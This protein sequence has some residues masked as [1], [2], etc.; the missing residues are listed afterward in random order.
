M[1]D[2]DR[3]LFAPILVMGVSACGKSEIA[4]RLAATIE[5]PFVEGDALHPPSNTDKMSRGVPLEDEDRWPWLNALADEVEALAAEKGGAVFS[6]SALK[7]SYRSRLRARLP[8]LI[9]VYLKLD[10]ETAQN[11]AAGRNGHFMPAALVE[12]QFATLECPRGEQNT[13][14]VDAR[15]PIEEILDRIHPAVLQLAV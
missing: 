8:D 4:S 13:V 12:S 15:M 7:Q 9:T 10:P 5:V 6:C 14:L 11:R 1:A 3:H 2:R